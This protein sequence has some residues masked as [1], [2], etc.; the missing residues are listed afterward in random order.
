MKVDGGIGNL[1]R[2]AS[3]AKAAEDA[4]YDGIWAA[5]TSQDPFL[6]L[7]IGAEHTSRV[8]LGTSIAVAFARNPMT[9]AQTAYDLQKFSGGRF[10]LGL[11]SQ[12]KPHITK[13]FSME[14]SHPAP[15]M[16]EMILAI[17]AIWDTWNNDTPLNFRGDFYTHTLMTPFFNPGPNPHGDAK[18]FIAG[19]GPVM[20]QVAGEVCDGFLVHGFTTESYLREVTLPALEAGMAKSGRDRADFELSFPAFVVTGTNEEE[21]AASAEATKR[22]IAFYGSTPAY[23]GVLEHHGWGELQSELNAL[24]KKGEWVQMG[25]L[26][27][28]EILNTF[29]V[30]GEPNQLAAE[31]KKRYA[32]VIDRISFYAPYQSNPEVWLPVISELR[33]G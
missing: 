26:I 11:G 25:T 13:R 18:I 28:D 14:W 7:I 9:L 4:G 16:R 10:I 3:E 22:Q 17:R 21:M 32:D 1:T 31:L 19:V 24:S 8:D 30:V 33:A 29:A 20:T 15:R 23:R 6:P 27:D 12:I 2:A 5:E